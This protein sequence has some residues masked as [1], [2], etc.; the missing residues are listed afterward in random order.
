MF[1]KR[2]Q[3]RQ[4]LLAYL[5][6]QRVPLHPKKSVSCLIIIDA[7]DKT[8]DNICGGTVQIMRASNNHTKK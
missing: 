1:S 8:F 3:M 4:K 5:T 6:L 2:V 7:C